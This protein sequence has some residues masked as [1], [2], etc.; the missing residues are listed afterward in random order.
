MRH[1]GLERKILLYIEDYKNNVD[2]SNYSDFESY[3]LR[4]CKGEK[5]ILTK[6]DVEYFG[7]SSGTTGSQKILPVTKTSRNIALKLNGILCQKLLYDSLKENW[8]Y[9]AISVVRQWTWT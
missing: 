5:N 6:E 7:H 8:T 3:I 2:L 9:P 1:F 4:E